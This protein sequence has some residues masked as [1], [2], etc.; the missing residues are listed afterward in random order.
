MY[1]RRTQ[2][3]TTFNAFFETS[4]WSRCIPTPTLQSRR[5]P[6]S[7]SPGHTNST[8]HPPSPLSQLWVYRSPKVSDPS[9]FPPP[10]FPWKV[11]PWGIISLHAS[12]AEQTHT[13][14]FLEN[15]RLSAATVSRK[16][17]GFSF[18]C[19]T[20]C[21]LRPGL[22]TILL[23]S[24]VNVYFFLPFCTTVSIFLFDFFET[25]FQF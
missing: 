21:F 18:V 20:W 24:R 10:F 1:S 14:T 16:I 5:L 23:G 3:D 11:L 15:F 25:F 22:Q 13:P 9:T 4:I 19:D 8:I 7:L 12:D 17:R 2:V 6:P